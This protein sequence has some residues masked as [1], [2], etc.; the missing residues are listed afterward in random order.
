MKSGGEGKWE[1]WI[2]RGGTFTDI[3]AKTPTGELLT[4]KLL[5][6]NPEAYRD[7]AIAGI[8]SFLGVSKGEPIP[9][10]KIEAVKMGT[11]VA[12]N[13]L[14]E[15]KGVPT[16][17]VTNKGFRDVLRIGYQN[18]P[19]IFARHIVKPELLYS[20][21][22]EADCRF[23]AKGE[24]L[25]DLDVE[26]VTKGL[27]SAFDQGYKSVAIVLIHG[28]RFTKHEKA[29]KDIASRI[30]FTQIS[31]SH[32]VSPLIKM[33]SRGDT[34]TVD[35]YLSPI[36][37]HYVDQVSSELKGTRLMFMQSNGGL[38]DAQLF[39]G[40]DSILSGPAG[41]IVGAAQTCEFEGITSLIGF[42]MG[43]T[44]T[45]VAMYTD[46]HY[47]RAY[48]TEV[49]GV[50]MRAPMMKIH[51]VAAGGGSILHFDGQRLLCGP[52]SA[53]AVPGPACYRRG[54]PLA[55]TDCNVML[56]KVRPEY[57]PMVFG[58]NGDQALDKK[59]V[60]EKFATLTAEINQKTSAGKSCHEIAEGFLSIA[61]ENM[62]SAIKD[63]SVRRGH[64][65]KKYT[66]CCFGGAGAQHAC[67][68][69]DALGMQQ[70][71]IHQLSGVLSAYGMGLA[72]IRAI[73]EMSVE[74]DLDEKGLADV[75]E[76]SQDLRKLCVQELQSQGVA[77]E[78][79]KTEVSVHLRYK[80]TDSSLQVGY[81]ADKA[82]LIK[83]FEAKHRQRYGFVPEGKAIVIEAVVVESLAASG[84][85]QNKSG[86]TPRKDAEI[87]LKPTAKVKMFTAGAEHE[88][89]VY[90]SSDLLL[91]DEVYGPAII[92]E[93]NSTVIVEPEWKAVLTDQR[94]LLLT[95]TQEK[96]RAAAVGT[97]RCDPVMLEIFN[98]LFM[99]CAEQM[100]ST[101]E[102]VSHSVNIKERLDFS[103][104]LFDSQG[105]LIANAPH[106]PVHLGSMDQSVKSIIK[107]QQ[108]IFQP[109]D[110]YAMNNPYNGGT[111]IPDVTV[112]TPVFA[113]EEYAKP[114]GEKPLFFVASR[115]HHQEIGGI[116]PGSV[117]PFSKHIEEEGVLI[118]N[119]QLVD[120]GVFREK[121]TIALLTG[122]KYPTRNYEM[123]LSDLR[124]QMAANE[125]GVQEIHKMVKQF[126]LPV[127][128][129]YMKYVQDN[130]EE[131]VRKVID[132]LKPGSFS[133]ATDDGCK[134]SVT[135]SID[136]KTRSAHLDF[137]G[138]DPQQNSN[139]N[140]PK[141]IAHAACLYVFRTLVDQP[142]PLN[143]GC[144]KPLKITL[145][146]KSMVNPVFPAAVVAGNVEVSQVV[147]DA[148]Y[149]ALGVLAGCQGTMNNFTFGNSKTGY[150]ETICGGSGAGPDFDGCD[151]VH[152]NMTNTRLTD[153][154][155]L[156]NRYPVRLETFEI[157]KGSG[158]K[159]THRGGDGIVREIRFLEPMTASIVSNRR[160]IAPY[161]ISGGSPGAVGINRLIKNN[162]EVKEL[163]HRAECKMEPGDIF[164]IETPGGG[165]FGSPSSGVSS[166]S[167]AAKTLAASVL[168]AGE[169]SGGSFYVSASSAALC[170]G[171][172]I[173]A[174]SAGFAL[175]RFSASNSR[176]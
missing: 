175:G 174:A 74:L 122:N 71:Y 125:R 76:K 50:R 160:K 47:E 75:D 60:E 80:G 159:G 28:Y 139:F 11:T 156:E 100:G 140:A 123:N 119:F 5:S 44:S 118:D 146:E 108:G 25:V 16:V 170:L 116:T 43:G 58:P 99:S 104:A 69:A 172:A 115:G 92:T 117:P 173:V 33:V 57:F 169:S 53:G 157:R 65:V 23:D 55:V 164:R 147:T 9:A 42:D 109:K 154:E 130:A 27:Q 35:A 89:N 158:G 129:T 137:T 148:L 106:V 176:N 151:A 19:D 59:V 4:K 83:K 24:E 105:N 98:N 15:R 94:S 36:L 135:V 127:V 168:G 12:T 34:T 10:E 77:Q 78:T 136:S 31:V 143:S 8:R 155:V 110:V 85:V 1:F 63:I 132:A 29:I 166:V 87:A 84:K 128:Q 2:D 67:L 97:D 7:A 161:G 64:D 40:K 45:D 144:M 113:E 51:T 101:L 41:G 82:E 37:R 21:T 149:G 56:G 32:E 72:D 66:L 171:V 39:Q 38:T 138:T 102:N 131:M 81:V 107:S 13:A 48:D 22:I 103:C 165:G 86:G 18:R 111:H 17:L 133:Y 120:R 26:G 49:A 96:K 90:A 14:L 73:R 93:P 152:T 114:T 20:H 163:S 88:T 167:S 124:A 91:G 95:R 3:V 79:P 46:N 70:V 141:A 30:G 150:Y 54:G 121:E 68:V 134:V 142:I 153:P 6:E 126:S 145:P 61:V 112:I 62:A 162:G 52:D